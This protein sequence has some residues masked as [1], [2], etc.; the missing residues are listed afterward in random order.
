MK[1]IG[2]DIGSYS[3]KVAEVVATTNSYKVIDYIEIPL[4]HNLSVDKK[5][6]IIDALRKIAH[7]YR[8]QK[9]SFSFAVR[10][11]LIS[12]RYKAFPFKERHKIIKSLPFQLVDDV[13]FDHNE[14]IYEAKFIATVGKITEV[15]AFICPKM[16]IRE[17]LSLVTDAGINPKIVTA[18]GAAT[19]NLISNWNEPPAELSASLYATDEDELSLL[20]MR[21]ANGVL[22]IGHQKTLFST[23]IDKNL[24][25]TH[26]LY[27]GGLHIIKSLMKKYEI[28]E[29]EAMTILIEKG[30]ILTSNLEEETEVSS[31]QRVFSETIKESFQ[32]L[33]VT[34]NRM[35]ISLSSKQKIA[36]D[37]IYLLGGTSGLTNIDVYLSQQFNIPCSLLNHSYD[38]QSAVKLPE[39]SSATA[40]G[41]AIE[42]LR[43]PRNPSV[44]FRKNDFAFQDKSFNRFWK[45]YNY[46]FKILA[47]SIAIFF[48]YT[49][50][51]NN[52][53]TNLVDVGYDALATQAKSPD[54]NLRRA[55]PSRIQKFIQTK[56]REIKSKQDLS[57]IIAIPT[58]LDTM[59]LISQQFINKK[60]GIVEIQKLSIQND[61]VQIEGEMSHQKQRTLIQNSLKKMAKNGKFQSIPPTFTSF[62]KENTKAPQRWPFAYTFIIKN[63]KQSP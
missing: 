5:I 41:I 32:Y 60:Q 43:R 53:T 58:A 16:H 42:S 24:I 52:L 35:L 54:I 3:I 36:F 25:Q 48:I 59:A 45:A 49:V 33:I 57:A 11:E 19:A 51:R 1:S 63:N 34:L 61:K 2:I 39:K 22:E 55:S 29:T 8:D 50:I 21:N 12:V 4:T 28:S 30:F 15:L 20:D 47:A 56:R 9:V 10:Q 13:P 23:Y 26:S 6:L 18:Q 27:F 17:L 46:S 62:S 38:H 40:I 44:N 31:D 7:H 37:H 14:A